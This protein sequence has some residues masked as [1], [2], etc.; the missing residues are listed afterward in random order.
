MILAFLG[1]LSALAA[2]VDEAV[3]IAAPHL[4]LGTKAAEVCQATPT[5]PAPFARS[6]IVI[7]VPRPAGGCTAIGAVIDGSY[8]TID[9]AVGASV[10]AKAWTDANVALRAEALTAWVMRGL[11]AFDQPIGSD[12]PAFSQDDGSLTISGLSWRAFAD[13]PG[14]WHNLRGAF[15]FGP[16]GSLLDRSAKVQAHSVARLS[17]KELSSSGLSAS[18][19][20]DVLSA[21]AGPLNRCVY[22]S[23]SSKLDFED[24]AKLKWA[25]AGGKATKFEVIGDS[26]DAIARC[27]ATA[28]TNTR[29][30]EGLT[31]SVTFAFVVR[32]TKP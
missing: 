1:L 6:V 18:S 12:K 29:F 3:L 17:L 7:G 30:P 21:N 4:P 23:Q 24:T 10:D 27:Y 9:E 15:T 14:A 31:G 16:T 19:V 2:P 26:D 32:Q 8:V 28:L 20:F 25:I 5:L 13:Q 11:L 22:A